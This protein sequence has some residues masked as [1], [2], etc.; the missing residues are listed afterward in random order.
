MSASRQTASPNSGEG[1]PAGSEVTLPIRSLPLVPDQGE[2]DQGDAMEG[3][4]YQG[5]K[6]RRLLGDCTDGMKQQIL[7]HRPDLYQSPLPVANAMKVPVGDVFDLRGNDVPGHL[8]AWVRERGRRECVVGFRTSEEVR[9]VLVGSSLVEDPVMKRKQGEQQVKAKKG[10]GKDAPPTPKLARDSI[11]ASFHLDSQT[12]NIQLTVRKQ[13]QEANGH[14]ILT[15]LIYA[16][17]IAVQHPTRAIFSMRPNSAGKLSEPL[18]GRDTVPLGS[19]SLV[20]LNTL[21][22]K[23]RLVE[24]SFLLENK[25]ERVWTGLRNDEVKEIRA[26]DE[27]LSRK[28]KTVSRDHLVKGLDSASWVSLYFIIKT[29]EDLEA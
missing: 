21:I 28:E 26:R 2:P 9:V 17:D 27:E 24:I 6:V 5:R 12:P 19:T 8:P 18:V 16:Q 23:R 11:K 14:E 4:S 1:K 15:T 29:A 3:L 22:E 20:E 7:A 10:K 25:E 13:G